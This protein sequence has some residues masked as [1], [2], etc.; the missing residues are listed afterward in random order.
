MYLHSAHRTVLYLALLP[1]PSTLNTRPRAPMFRQ[2]IKPIFLSFLTFLTTQVLFLSSSWSHC[3]RY[4]AIV[5]QPRR[6][7][8]IVA[9]SL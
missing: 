3:P 1:P 5:V 2:S 7:P 6:Y 8:H 4:L 9:Y